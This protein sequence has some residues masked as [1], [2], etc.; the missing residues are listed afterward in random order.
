M[1]IKIEVED[2]RHFEKKLHNDSTQDETASQNEIRPQ[3][4]NLI[5]P[6]ILLY[7][8]NNSEK[9]KKTVLYVFWYSNRGPNPKF[10]AL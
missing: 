8:S 7:F 1:I 10:S 4:D 6:H 9:I 2:V 3:D 5:D